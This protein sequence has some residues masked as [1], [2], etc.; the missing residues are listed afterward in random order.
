MEEWHFE[1]IVG[2]TPCLN[3]MGNLSVGL[4]ELLSR[5]MLVRGISLIVVDLVSFYCW[6]GGDFDS[7]AAWFLSVTYEPQPPFAWNLW[8][9][10]DVVAFC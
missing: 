4:G 2:F 9:L 8:F 1:S 10:A 5:F 3:G 7:E 6:I